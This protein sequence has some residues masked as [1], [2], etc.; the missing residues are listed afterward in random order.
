[1]SLTSPIHR[2]QRQFQDTQ[3]QLDER[4]RR[5]RDLLEQLGGGRRAAGPRYRQGALAPAQLLPPVLRPG[6]KV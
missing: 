6:T 5:A 3:A 1:M 2:I 4:K